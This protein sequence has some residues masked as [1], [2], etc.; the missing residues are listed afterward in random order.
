M[1]WPKKEQFTAEAQ[2]AQCNET[3]QIELLA[4]CVIIW[5]S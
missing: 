1:K 2:S 5:W 3:A 4:V